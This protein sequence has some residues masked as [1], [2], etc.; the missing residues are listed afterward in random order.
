[1]EEEKN[2]NGNEGCSFLAPRRAS[3]GA[4]PREQWSRKIEFLFACVGFAVGYGNFWRF[5]FKC[6][7]NGGGA[8][9]I[10]FLI[11]LVLAGIPL[12]MLELGL[13]QLTQAGPLKAWRKI[14]PLMTGIGYGMVVVCFLVSIYYNVIL[15]WSCFYFF[16]SFKS[17]LPWDGGMASTVG[18]LT[19]STNNLTVDVTSQSKY[20]F[21]H[22]VLNI[23]G[24]VDDYGVINWKVTLCLLLAWTL[25]YF[26][27][28]KGIR[29]TGKVVY[30]TA[31]L[32]YVMLLI[33][34]IHGVQLPGATKGIMY[35]ITPVWSMLAKPQV[36]VDAASQ[37]FYSLTLGFG[38]MLTFASYNK[39]DNNLVRDALLI[40]II[41]ALT[42]IF[43]GVVVFTIIGYLAEVQGKEVDD[44][45]IATDGPGL[46]FIV[47]PAALATLPQPQIWSV[48]FFLMLITLGLDSQFGQVE[49]ICA[50][51]IEQYPEKLKKRKEWVVLAVCVLLFLCGL[52]CM[53]RSGMYWFNLI[54]NF[55]AGISLL[56]LG[57]CELITVGWI[58]GANNFRT[59]IESLV[60]FQISSFW[61]I[62][63]KFV[64]P[65][66]VTAIFLS[67]LITN[68]PLTYETYM[69]PDWSQAVGWLMAI[70]SMI[71][72]PVVALLSWHSADGNTS[73]E[74]LIDS[75]SA[76]DCF[77]VDKDADVPLYAVEM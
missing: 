1:M 2:K 56:F 48:V 35:Y 77:K 23:S 41:D 53:T 60:G 63:W 49:L 26:C 71:C 34:F 46:V 33:F 67:S 52:I 24:A 10:P 69:Y 57:L 17:T 12:F 11:C 3:Q 72:V 65:V 19:N 68:K 64:T 16:N 38:V 32:P 4:P 18:N 62:M 43:S 75:M 20:F 73:R 58:F 45:T 28:F 76:V 50:A 5:P 31:T 25:V 42:S 55:S 36:W 47:Y 27:I 54:D 30:I 15:A 44:P 39:Q 51:I 21:E 37:V 7:K 66:I 59:Q 13:G 40:S 70:A 61:I 29:T 74:K 8:F 22:E 9:L 6:F 14:C